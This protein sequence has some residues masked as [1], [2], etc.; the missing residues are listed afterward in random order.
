MGRPRY[1]LPTYCAAALNP[2]LITL[3]TSGGGSGLG[4]VFAWWAGGGCIL[5]EPPSRWPAAPDG[6]REFWALWSSYRLSTEVRGLDKLRGA[7]DG[8][9]LF[10]DVIMEGDIIAG[11]DRGE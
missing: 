6:E 11:G 3:A 7:S 4:R 2:C 9:T 5:G 1:G 10:G 8:V